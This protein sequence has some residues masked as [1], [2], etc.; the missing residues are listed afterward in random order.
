MRI[1]QSATHRRLLT[2][3]SLV[4]L[5]GITFLIYSNT[6]DSPFE[7]DDTEKITENPAIRM[8]EL[9]WEGIKTAVLGSRPKSRPL[10]NISFALNFYMGR[11]NVIGYHLTN[12]FIH[13]AAGLL[14]FFLVRLTLRSFAP[15]TGTRSWP[16][17]G[18]LAFFASL[19]WLVQPVNTQAVTYTVQRM[20][21]M[22]ALFFILSLFL[23]AW[24][25]VQWRARGKLTLAAALAFSGC[26]LSGTCAILSKENAAM[27]PIIILLYE[28]FFFQ[29]LSVSIPKRQIL[30]IVG[31]ILIF[32]VIAICY[33]G[34]NP[35]D[36]ILN[37]YTQQ[38]FTLPER[39]MTEWRVIIYYVSLFFYPHSVR[40]ILDHDY[41]LS[42][43]LAEPG[44]TLFCLGAVFALIML[45]IYLA[46]RHRFLAFCLAWFLATL[47]IESSVI[48]LDT[49]FEHRTYLPFMLFMAGG[50]YLALGYIR[51]T[52]AAIIGLCMVALVFS[53]W[54]WQR[55]TI[56]QSP[57]D[58]WT[59]NV[60]KSPNDPRPHG[61]L[62]MAHLDRTYNDA[63]QV[64]R[65]IHHCKTALALGSGTQWRVKYK[66]SVLYNLGD[67]LRRKG[68]VDQA[69]A[70][71]LQVL[72]IKPMH[73]KARINLASILIQKQRYSDALAH[74]EP[75]LSAESNAEA[76]VN[77]G[78]A[79]A[80]INRIDE[81]VFH[82]RKALIIHP[83]IA[84]THNNL[85]VLLIQKGD[86]QAA[87][88]HFK[89]ALRLRP[90]YGNARQN[91]EKLR[92]LE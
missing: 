50:A 84:E 18:W 74:L 52:K 9:S 62:G 35:L 64:D 24:G 78:V 87:Q 89:T 21:S 79:F 39:V 53:I 27:L 32:S 55:N 67:A 7:F 81:A 73:T 17:P 71:Y 59:D 92:T 41:P 40:L 15:P 54:T 19:L 11:Y 16:A 8:T 13:L 5:A 68:Q 65:A 45:C 85:G 80:H 82:F 2:A 58:L 47:V 34:V 49:I 14:L 69:V 30:W 4:L 1:T 23:Y 86:L 10:P 37:G 88:S 77:A 26:V 42:Y 25:R 43:S 36:R 75:V 38:E 83:D 56:W 48:G 70:Y 63:D 44:T 46:R 90:E 3:A 76:H 20:A 22:A 51:P 57:I 12:I 91:L 33:L 66:W 29:D 6:L 72:E 28:W 60:H 61:S 31:V